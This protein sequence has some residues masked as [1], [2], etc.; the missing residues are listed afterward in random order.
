MLNIGTSPKSRLRKASTKEELE[1]NL[2]KIG[3]SE[4]DI[5]YLFEKTDFSN[6]L[7]RNHQL[8]FLNDFYI[9]NYNKHLTS[10]Q[11]ALVFDMNPR[12]VRKNLATGPQDPKEHTHSVC[13]IL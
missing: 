8:H 9:K 5:R 12:T 6:L 13:S 11:L 7:Y 3:M 10:N 2:K 4:R 1:E